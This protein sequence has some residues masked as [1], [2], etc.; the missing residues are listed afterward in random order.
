M[1][2]EASLLPETGRFLF[3]MDQRRL[4]DVIELALDHGPYTMAAAAT[5]DDALA[6]S[7]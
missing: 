7:D 2:N 1:K 3:I 6:V 4:A 5:I